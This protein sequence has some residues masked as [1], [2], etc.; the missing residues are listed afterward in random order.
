MTAA[1]AV[2]AAVAAAAAVARDTSFAT[3]LPP[4]NVQN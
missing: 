3:A 1:A 4:N 2:A